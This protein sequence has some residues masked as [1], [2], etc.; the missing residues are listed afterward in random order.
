[1]FPAWLERDPQN[2][3]FLKDPQKYLVKLHATLHDI[4]YNYIWLYISC[5]LGLDKI[6]TSGQAYCHLVLFF[7]P[8]LEMHKGKSFN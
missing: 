7:L 2:Y 5:F 3:F 4:T 6:C 1:M 8:Q